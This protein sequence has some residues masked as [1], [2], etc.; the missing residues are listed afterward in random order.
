MQKNPIKSSNVNFD[1]IA[2]S[3]LIEMKNSYK[4]LIGYLDELI[5]LLILMSPKKSGYIKSF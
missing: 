3:K 5:I 1:S 2:I 4:Q